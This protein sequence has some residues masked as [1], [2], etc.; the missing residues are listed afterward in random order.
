[1]LNMY[2]KLIG[3]SSFYRTT[4]YKFRNKTGCVHNIRTY[5]V[6]RPICSNYCFRI[7]C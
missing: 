1:M 3:N 6:L 4:S 5:P 7:S 2:G